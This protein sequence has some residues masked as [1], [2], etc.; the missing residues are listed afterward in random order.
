[1]VIR[2]QGYHEIANYIDAY[3]QVPTKG[4]YDDA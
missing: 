4:V 1:M 2:E 3:E